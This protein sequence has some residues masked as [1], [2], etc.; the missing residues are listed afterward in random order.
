[1]M[2]GVV[3]WD[4]LGGRGGKGGERRRERKVGRESGEGGESIEQRAENGRTFRGPTE[5]RHFSSAWLHLTVDLVN[6]IN[7]QSIAALLRHVIRGK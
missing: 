6:Q 7:V 1:V 3:S 4:V 5:F 2:R